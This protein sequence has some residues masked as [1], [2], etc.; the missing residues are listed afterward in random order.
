MQSDGTRPTRETFMKALTS[1]D[2][3]LIRA[4]YYADMSTAVLRAVSMDTALPQPT[5]RSLATSVELCS[6]PQGYLG[7]S[8]EVSC[9][10]INENTFTFHTKH[11]GASFKVIP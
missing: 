11:I 10:E 1:V 7:L 5:S 6:C 3:I 8:C 4:T 9:S 2:A